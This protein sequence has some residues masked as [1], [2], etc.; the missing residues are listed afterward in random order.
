MSVNFIPVKVAVRIRPLA[1]SEKQ[2]N[3]IGFLHKVSGE[4]QVNPNYLTNFLSKINLLFNFK[5]CFW[6]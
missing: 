3:A 5:I 1:Q 4:P 2:N 6:L